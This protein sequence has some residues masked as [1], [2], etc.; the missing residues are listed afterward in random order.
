MTHTT[1]TPK[2]II[3]ISYS[4]KPFLCQLHLPIRPPDI[5]TSY[6]GRS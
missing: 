6:V 2:A 3:R 4:A 1:I 5:V